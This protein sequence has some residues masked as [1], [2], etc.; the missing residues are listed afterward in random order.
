MLT[1]FDIKMFDVAELN[2]LENP[3][4]VALIEQDRVWARDNQNSTWFALDTKTMV[5]DR[6]IVGARALHDRA[7]VP[8]P[9]V[10]PNN[11]DANTTSIT[12]LI[13]LRVADP[14]TI[15]V[16]A[17]QSFLQTRVITESAY[18]V[19]LDGESAV[20]PEY[21]YPQMNGVYDSSVTRFGLTLQGRFG[22][23]SDAP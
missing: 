19:T 14:L 18:G 1:G 20:D 9:M 5:G 6:W 10:S 15:S 16:R 3:D 12:G 2:G 4:T 13:A 11:Y 7:A 21:F 22:A 8:D 23:R 17:T